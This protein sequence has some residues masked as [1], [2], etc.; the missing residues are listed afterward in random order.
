MMSQETRAMLVDQEHRFAHEVSLVRKSGQ[1][2]T[3]CDAPNSDTRQPSVIDDPEQAGNSLCVVCLQVMFQAVQLPCNHTG[4]TACIVKL[5]SMKPKSQQECP[6]CKQPFHYNNLPFAMKSLDNFIG[7]QPSWCPQGPDTDERKDMIID[8]FVYG[9][10]SDNSSL[11]LGG[12]AAKNKGVKMSVKKKYVSGGKR[13][14]TA[15][16][17]AAELEEVL[18]AVEKVST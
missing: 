14:R 11:G 1:T 12:A 3:D 7:S 9:Y 17:D 2:D 15:E 18:A 10:A 5:R 4:C 6:L 13:K 8:P 16:D